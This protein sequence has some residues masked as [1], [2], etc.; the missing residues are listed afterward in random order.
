LKEWRRPEAPGELPLLSSLRGFCA[1]TIVARKPQSV[2]GSDM[3]ETD[4]ARQLDVLLPP[5]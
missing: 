5:W 3:A 4:L 2:E 1:V